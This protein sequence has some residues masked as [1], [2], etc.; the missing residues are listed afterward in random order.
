M[1]QKVDLISDFSQLS[2][3]NLVFLKSEFC[4]FSLQW[5]EMRRICCSIVVVGSERMT[6]GCHLLHYAVLYTE[7]KYTTS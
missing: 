3:L 2:A 4:P 7:Y 6:S 5:Y 1:D